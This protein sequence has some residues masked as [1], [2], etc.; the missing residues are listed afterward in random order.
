MTY[1][2]HQRWYD[3]RGWALIVALV[4]LVAAYLIGS[5]ALNTGSWQQYALT[6]VFLVFGLSRLFR[7]VWPE[8]AK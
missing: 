5:R 1:A 3:Q 4:A 8:K 6:F 2:T 7:S